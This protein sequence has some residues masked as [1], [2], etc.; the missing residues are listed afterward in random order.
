MEGGDTIPGLAVNGKWENVFEGGARE[1]LE[2]SVLP[3]HVRARRWFGGKARAIQQLQ[4]LEDIR[5]EKDSAASHLLF[6]EVRYTEGRP[7][8]YLLPVAF[9]VAEKAKE[10]MESFPPGVIARLQAGETEGILYDG[11][12]D[13]RFRQQLLRM[14]A[15]KEKLRGNRGELAAYPTKAFKKN[16]PGEGLVLDSQVLTV[17]QSNSA[18][19]YG[20]KF[21]LKLFRRLDEGLNPDLEIGGFITEKTS[22]THI[23]R[24]T[25][26]LEYTKAGSGVM[27]LGILQVFVPNAGDAWKYTLGAIGR[28]FERVLSKRNEIQEMPQPASALLELAFQEIPAA[29]QE[30]IGGV[31]LARA[32][33]LG[34][35]T[36]ELHLALSANAADPNFAPEPLS[37]L[38][39]RSICQSMQSLAGRNFQLLAKNVKTLPAEIKT[40]AEKLLSREQDILERFGAIRK[41]KI[42]AMKIRIH[43]DYHLGQVLYT[44][45]DFVIIDFEG[46]PAKALSERRLKRSPFRDVAGMIRSFHYAVYTGLLKKAAIRREDVPLLKP[47][48]DLWY[49]YVAGAF[50]KSYLETAGQAPFMPNEKHEL[51]VLLRT[52]LLEKA[53]Y[54]LGYELNSRPD[55]LLIPINGIKQLLE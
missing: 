4:I 48:A 11:V 27:I 9:A 37:L 5:L 42:S 17:E 18:L 54:E 45:S 55:W 46:E 15:N 28:Y 10:I 39:Q 20:D 21:F 12:Y 23:P 49:K 19:I 43:G 33:L 1:K 51:D 8:V 22:Y 53:V 41:K 50:L 38:Y 44:G 13:D 26:A 29:A 30:L 36:A 14:I 3:A 2:A 35:R 47:W 25:G 52:F 34:K 40:E 24:V 16:A 32:H 31:Y 7:E 6:L